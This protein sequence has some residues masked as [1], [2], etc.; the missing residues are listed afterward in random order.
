MTVEERIKYQKEKEKNKRDKRN[1]SN[2]KSKII[3]QEK[4]YAKFD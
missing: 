1:N 4:N 2:K 3:N